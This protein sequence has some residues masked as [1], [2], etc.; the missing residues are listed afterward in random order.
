L[1]SAPP[2]LPATGGTEVLAERAAASGA[3]NLAATGRDT[4]STL[5][6]GVILL[7]S[8]TALLGASTVLDRSRRRARRRV[9][10]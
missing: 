9:V 6:D 2:L 5:N 3:T 10:G 4:Q 8:G 7:A 1:P